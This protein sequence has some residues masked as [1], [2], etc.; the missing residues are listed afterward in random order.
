MQCETTANLL[1][2][3]SHSRGPWIAKRQILQTGNVPI[4]SGSGMEVAFATCRNWGYGTEPLT[5]AET[6]ANARLI[7][8]SPSML[9][10]LKLLVDTFGPGVDSFGD[11]AGAGEIDAIKEG[12]AAISLA[13]LAR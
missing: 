5:N 12:R 11:G 9:Q 3:A 4:V 1:E 13:T 2:K 10:A 6:V 8:A 7:A